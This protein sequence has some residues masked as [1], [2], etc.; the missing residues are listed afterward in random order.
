MIPITGKPATL[1]TRVV[2]RGFR[3]WDWKATVKP[4]SPLLSCNKSYVVSWSL[5]GT[6]NTKRKARS[7][8]KSALVHAYT[9]GPSVAL[10]TPW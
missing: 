6:A 8:A 9:D 5:V 7:E 2:R 1:S 10:V 3:K 4:A